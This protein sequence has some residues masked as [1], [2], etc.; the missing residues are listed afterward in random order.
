[1]FAIEFGG[2]W[3]GVFLMVVPRAVVLLCGGCFAL[4]LAV[5]ESLSMFIYVL[6]L[7]GGDVDLLDTYRWVATIFVT[8]AGLLPG[9][10]CNHQP[11]SQ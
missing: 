7:E 1:V 11:T 4:A 9:R 2:Y 8:M 5:A 6:I 3:D 10:F